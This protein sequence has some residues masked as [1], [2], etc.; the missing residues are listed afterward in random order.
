MTERNAFTINGQ[1]CHI[2][3]KFFG[4]HLLTKHIRSACGGKLARAAE[5][6]NRWDRGRGSVWVFSPD[7]VHDTFFK[8]LDEKIYEICE[9][10][11]N[12]YGNGFVKIYDCGTLKERK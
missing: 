11:T 9:K 2:Y 5:A 1:Q 12:F 6:G 3:E 10:E 7:V 8:S 4:R